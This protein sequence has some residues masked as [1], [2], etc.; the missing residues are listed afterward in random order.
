MQRR[1]KINN[2]LFNKLCYRDNLFY[3]SRLV[4][5]SERGAWQNVPDYTGLNHQDCRPSQNAVPPDW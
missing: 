3:Y 4:I 1:F 5:G 2:L